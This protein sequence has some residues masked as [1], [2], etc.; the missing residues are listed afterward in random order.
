MKI[1]ALKYLGA[2]NAIYIFVAVTILIVISTW[3]EIMGG[4]DNMLTLMEKQNHTLMET[5]LTASRNSIISS[6]RFEEYIQEKLLDNAA[7]IKTAYENGSVT[8]FYLSDLAAARDIFRI[9][10][11]DKTGKN[12]YSSRRGRGGSGKPAALSPIFSGEVDT[13]IIG[14]KEAR[15]ADDFRYVAALKTE[16]GGVIVVNVNATELISYR[17]KTGFGALIREVAQHPGIVYA[18]LQN[19]SGILAGAG[20]LNN[21]NRVEED[22]FLINATSDTSVCSR[23]YSD[24]TIEVYETV[25]AFYMDEDFIGLL[26]LGISLQPLDEM[27]N[28]IYRRS[29]ILGLILAVFGSI[30]ISYLFNTQNYSNLRRDYEAVEAKAS[31]IFSRISEAIFIVDEKLN[32]VEKNNSAEKYLIN[33]GTL[34][35]ALQNVISEL[36]SYKEDIRSV[37]LNLNGKKENLFI[38]KKEFLSS[39]KEKNY[40]IL[41]NEL[42]RI[43]E[44]EDKI[45]RSERQRAMGELAAGVAH[46]IRNPLNSIGVIVQH[47]KKDFSVAEDSEEFNELTSVVYDEVKRINKTISDFLQFV[48][49]GVYNKRLISVSELTEKIELQYKNLFADEKISFNVSID[50]DVD[51]FVDKEKIYQSLVNLV[52]NAAAAVSKG[53]EI[54]ISFISKDDKLNIEVFDTGCGIKPDEIEKVFNLYFTTKAEGT[55][56]GLGVVQKIIYEHGGT[57]TVESEEKKFTRFC[58]KL[59]LKDE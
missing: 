16:D 47:L 56:L 22:Q 5:L 2:K 29:F 35:V 6:D 38:S 27:Y 49:P 40:I 44:L 10:I 23:I 30:I 28:R 20:S 14:L 37:E 9:N 4:R 53:G 32:I 1:P 55:G 13:L 45:I 12:I 26:R 39:E 57:I 34:H 21:I 31:G 51:I 33:E 11:F 58:I 7:Y 50:R 54:K 36:I 48:K 41:I 24:E 46:E 15:F 17:N 18:A 25:H 42:T 19:E 43:K 52:E 3:F 8:N 59:P